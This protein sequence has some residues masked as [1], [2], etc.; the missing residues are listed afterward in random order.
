MALNLI[1]RYAKAK[2][3]YS[4]DNK[5]KPLNEFVQ[6]L[7]NDLKS[8][9]KFVQNTTFDIDELEVHDLNEE[10]DVHEA[11]D[12]IKHIGNFSQLAGK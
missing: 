8:L 1:D 12:L 6:S 7:A 11:L 10:I 5:L 4:I 9:K 3:N 2:F